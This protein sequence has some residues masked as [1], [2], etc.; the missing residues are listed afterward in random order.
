MDR[1]VAVSV[2]G[3][4]LLFKKFVVAGVGELFEQEKKDYL[5]LV[6]F[7]SNHERGFVFVFLS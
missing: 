4:L 6:V 5:L 7:N 1:I 3:I 2:L